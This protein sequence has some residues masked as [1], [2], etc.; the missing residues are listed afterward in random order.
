MHVI[1]RLQAALD[2]VVREIGRRLRFP[3]REERFE[4]GAGEPILAIASNILE[5][6]IAERHMREALG[7]EAAT[8]AIMRSYS[9]F[10]QG[11][12]SGTT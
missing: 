4:P 1:L 9:A 11:H 5:E 3:D 7:H 8:A 2:H 10:E 12:G 6:Q